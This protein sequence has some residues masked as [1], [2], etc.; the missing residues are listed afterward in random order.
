MTGGRASVR[1][2]EPGD[3]M[4]EDTRQW[5]EALEAEWS[6]PDGFL[7]KAREGVFDER[8]GADFVALLERIELADGPLIDRRLVA[9]VW[10]MPQF[11]RWQEE[12][13]AERGG[14]LAAFARLTTRVHGIV[15]AILGV[16]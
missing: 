11:L 1:A 16:P 14:D 7:R 12:R 8:Q 15:E 9:L 5:I 13:V 2:V 6:M 4:K 3:F 10:Y